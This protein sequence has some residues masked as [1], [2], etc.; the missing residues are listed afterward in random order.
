[1]DK[2]LII[3]VHG[4]CSNIDANDAQNKLRKVIDTPSCGKSV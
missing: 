4:I 1:M 3:S 2:T